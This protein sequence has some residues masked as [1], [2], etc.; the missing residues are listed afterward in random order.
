[1]DIFKQATK[2]RLRFQT[3]KGPLSVEQLWDL[4]LTDLDTLAVSLQETYETSKGKSFLTKRTTKNAAVKLQFD[5]VLDVLQTK[6]EEADNLRELKEA[7]EHDNKIL[8]LIEE[9]KDEEL[10]GKSV[11]ELRKLLKTKVRV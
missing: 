2:E 3:N 9:K 6:V 10:K 8:G 5:I 7:K 1:M 11:A 4:S